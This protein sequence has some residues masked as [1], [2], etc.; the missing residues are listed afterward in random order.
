MIFSSK[1]IEDA[2]DEFSRLPGIG[3]KTALRM[4]LQLM[5]MDKEKVDSFTGA[6]SRM[7]H[8]IQF[9]KRCHNVSDGEVCTICAN[10][11]RIRTQ[12]CIVEN[13]R[14][15]IAI[16]STQ[17][18]NGTYHILG[19]ILSP[20]DGIGPEQLN[21]ASVKERVISEE[22]EEL[23]MALS[24]TIEGDTTVYYIA[25]QL[26]GHPVR[27]TT[28]ARGISFGGELEY[29]DEMTLARSIAKRQPVEH[30]VSVGSKS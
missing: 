18:Y 30:Y 20:L 24:P 9:C 17:Q 1:L 14:D 23:I 6:L 10:P 22:A 28:I 26:Q 2:V 13:I 29:A 19:G 12:I 27:I 3:K 15:V 25:R 16:E 11:G 4:V 21:I 7:R 8:E 5:K